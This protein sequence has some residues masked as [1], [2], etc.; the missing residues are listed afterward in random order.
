M[1]IKKRIS[2]AERRHQDYLRRNGLKVGRVYESRLLKLRKKEVNRL[3][4][5][6]KEHG[7]IDQWAGVIDT[8]LD[9]SYLWD[10][11][12][13]LYVDAGLPKARSTARDMSRGKAA[14]DDG[15]WEDEIARYAQG[16]AGEKIVL[17]QGTLKEELVGIVRNQMALDVQMPIEKLARQIFADYSKIALWQARRIAQT[18]TMIS[19]AGA[20]DIAARSLDVKFSKQWATSGLGN[21]RDSHLAMDGTIVYDADE[22]FILPSGEL[23]MYPHDSSLGASAGEIIN[24]A[25]D[26]I[27]RPI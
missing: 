21:T 13:G 25:C 17:V 2:P 8:Y 9:E 12:K 19:L 1:A 3:L 24:C 5:L 27:R 10:W 14:P 7:G 20:G 4:S 18:E 15:Y 16:Q 22:P 26:V 11:Y 23:M 6:C